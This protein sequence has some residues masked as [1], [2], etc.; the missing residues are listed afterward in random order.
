MSHPIT[1]GAL[2]YGLKGRPDDQLIMIED[3]IVYVVD[4]A[5][6]PGIIMGAEEPAGVCPACGQPKRE[7][8]WATEH[9]AGS[10]VHMCDPYVAAEYQ[11]NKAQP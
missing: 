10:T 2:R 7:G 1:V 6:V 5:S 9:S 3:N 4:P 11:R 8:S